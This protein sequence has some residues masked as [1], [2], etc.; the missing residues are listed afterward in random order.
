MHIIQG[1]I[2]TAAEVTA[3]AV[4][5]AK[6]F[7]V[8][9]GRLATKDESGTLREY[10]YTSEVGGGGGGASIPTFSADI[11]VGRAI[12]PTDLQNLLVYNSASNTD[13]TIPND[14]TLGIAGGSLSNAS[15][16]IYQKGNG[17]PNLVAGSGVTLN[18]WVGYPTSAIGVTQTVHRVGANTWAVK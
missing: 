7:F 17:V 12:A 14:T 8:T 9:G 16:E 10:A 2:T 4:G 13:F 5:K 1:I 3:A 18:K 11:T 6:L 15:F